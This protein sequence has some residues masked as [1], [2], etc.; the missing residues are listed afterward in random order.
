L[1]GYFRFF[2]PPVRCRGWKNYEQE[3]F[4]AVL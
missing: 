2:Y 4:N 3:I 1:N